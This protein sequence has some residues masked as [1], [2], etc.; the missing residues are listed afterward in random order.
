MP[1]PLLPL[2]FAGVTCAAGVVGCATTV[3]RAVSSYKLDPRV[4]ARKQMKDLAYMKKC[5]ES[6]KENQ[7]LYNAGERTEKNYLYYDGLYRRQIAWM[8]ERMQDRAAMYQPVQVPPDPNVQ[9]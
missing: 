3:V 7:A 1:L 5:Q 8:H 6:L 4:A 9:V 2:V